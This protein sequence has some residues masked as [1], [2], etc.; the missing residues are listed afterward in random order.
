[1]L[2]EAFNGKPHSQASFQKCHLLQNSSRSLEIFL[3]GSEIP[4]SF[5]VP[6]TDG[7]SNENL[8]CSFLFF[9]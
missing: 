4:L 1:M 7:H 5:S 2:F 8:N 3:A 6:P 9:L